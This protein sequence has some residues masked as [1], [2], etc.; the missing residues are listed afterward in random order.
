MI[1]IYRYRTYTYAHMHTYIHTYIHTYKQTN[2]FFLSSNGSTCYF[3]FYKFSFESYEGVL[4]KYRKG[5]ISKG[6][7]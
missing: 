7:Y 5:I 2:E 1:N 3:H 4:E 6:K